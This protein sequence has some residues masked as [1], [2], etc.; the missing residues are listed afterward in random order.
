MPLANC[1]CRGR[2]RSRLARAATASTSDK[3]RFATALGSIA[4]R[5]RTLNCRPCTVH[6]SVC[7]SDPYARRCATTSTSVSAVPPRSK[8][9]VVAR[10]PQCALQPRLSV[11]AGPHIGVGDERPGVT[12]CSPRRARRRQRSRR[13]VPTRRER[14]RFGFGCD[15]M[16]FAGGRRADGEPGNALPMAKTSLCASRRHFRARSGQA[17]RRCCSMRV[18][19]AGVTGL[20][21]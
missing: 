4:R 8:Q 1:Q 20:L 6:A 17:G 15:R 5:S 11:C 19:A 18:K 13:A 9:D 7:A 16:D 10:R 12:D 2:R 14:R 21:K 3:L